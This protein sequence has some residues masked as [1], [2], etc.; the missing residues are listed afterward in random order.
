LAV[1]I[2]SAG[3]PLLLVIDDMQWSDRDTLEWLHYLLR[4]NPRA[5]L[6]LMGTARMDEVDGIHPLNE[7]AMALK[8]AGM[9]SEIELGPLSA[10]ETASL[11]AQVAGHALSSSTSADLYRETEGNPLFVVET[12]RAEDV[13]GIPSTVQAVIEQRLSRLPASSRETVQLAATIGRA[14]SL[15]VMVCASTN[16]DATLARTLDDLVQ[17]NIIREHADAMLHAY[18]FTHGHIREVAYRTIGLAQRRLL[19]NRVADALLQCN[20]SRLD[21]TSAQI[22]MHYDQGGRPEKA[23]RFYE[24]AAQAARNMY[25]NAEA[26]AHLQRAQVL[27]KAQ[28]ELGSAPARMVAARIGEALG[29]ML[30]HS[31]RYEDAREAYEWALS[32]AS[33]V[34]ERALLQR[35]IGNILRETHRYD[36]AMVAYK[37]A[38]EMLG[39]PDQSHAPAWW[40][41]WIQVQLEIDLVYYWVGNVEANA[42]LLNHLQPYLMQHGTASQ[43]ASFYQNMTYRQFRA[44][45]NVATENMV[46]SANLALEAFREAGDDSR[47]PA[48]TFGVGF[49]LMWHGKPKE[50]E[51]PLRDALRMAERTGDISLKARCITYLGLIMRQMDRVDA[52]DHFVAEG[53]KVAE[54]AGMPEYTAMAHAN[55][56]WVAWRRDEWAGVREHGRK[57]LEIWSQFPIGHASTVAR[58]TGLL[59]L[60]ALGV[61]ERDLAGAAAHAQTL[62]DP[63][64]HKLP[65]DVSQSLEAAIAAWQA[66][67]ARDNLHALKRALQLAEQH[68]LL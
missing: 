48:A 9:F 37:R 25:A 53:F 63:H 57:A 66:G 27:L 45:R 31:T 7:L 15:D 68:H 21:G 56:A 35:K 59:P 2:Q 22:A 52:C 49:V 50:A 26:I 24:Q 6:L 36:D 33:E 19:H 3:S 65:D 62:L 51:A 67:D 46:E 5:R 1:T 42:A 44:N 54:A 16:D 30:L 38:S 58:W 10:I 55:G 47:V 13:G 60:I 29:D 39:E 32:C 34:L 64:L 28:V 14:F 17:C 8:H 40:H 20:A 23:V 43:R 61:R 4:H 12:M 41:E 11:A 18:D